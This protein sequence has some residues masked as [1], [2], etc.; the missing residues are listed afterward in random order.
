MAI[1]FPRAFPT[2]T[3]IKSINLRA[4][5]QSAISASPF[6]YKQQVHNHTGERWEAEVSLPP[7][8]RTDAEQWIAWL[9]SMGGMSGTFLMGDPLGCTARGAASGTPII[10][11]AGQTGATV[12]VDG[13]TA[14]ITGWLKAGDYIQLGGGSSATLHK[15]LQD[16][17]SN[18]AGQAS[19][20][21]WPALRSSP[22]DGSTVVAGGAEGR[23]RLI[24]SEVN[25]SIDSTAAFG[26][27]F[28]AI[29]AIA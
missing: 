1:S 29:E 14:S 25:W 26:L 12:A 5:N 20:D 22:T 24:T 6:T 13:C 2:H 27:T 23:W 11:G 16:A 19:L 15:V 21:I 9:M 8:K 10:N 7:M 17:D 18:A 28:G 3:G 4:V